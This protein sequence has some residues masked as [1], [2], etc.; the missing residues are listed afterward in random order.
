MTSVPAAF[1]NGGFV[2]PLRSL[3]LKIWGYHEETGGSVNKFSLYK[4]ESTSDCQ[5]TIAL[6]LLSRRISTREKESRAY[7]KF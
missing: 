5:M 2:Y 1:L 4:D 6:F 7:D 3:V